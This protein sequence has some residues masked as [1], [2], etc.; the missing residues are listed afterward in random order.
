MKFKDYLTEKHQLTHLEHL[1]DV[2]FLEGMK[3]AK[4]SLD[5]IKKIVEDISKHDT[6]MV[7][8]QKVDG[9]PSIIAGWSPED[10]RF[11]VGTKSFFNKTPKINYTPEDVD[12]NHGHSDGLSKKLKEGLKYLPKVIKKGE[13]LQGDFM[14][15]QDDLKS[16]K[17]DGLPVVTFTPNTITYAVPKDTPLYKK[18]KDA[19]IGVIF[20][21]SYSGNTL[22]S[23]NGSFKISDSQLNPSKDVYYRTTNATIDN[24]GWLPGE[25]KR[26]KSN[27]KNLENDLRSFNQKQ[28]D[29]ISKNKKL[30]L[31]IRTYINEKVRA[32]K[33]KFDKNE[34]KGLIDYIGT[35]YQKDIDKLKSEKGKEKKIKE[36]QEFI[37]EL[38]NY[39]STLYHL[40]DWVYRVQDTKLYILRKLQQLN[41]PETPYIKTSDG[42]KVTDP[43]GFVLSS[44][45]DSGVK[46][47]NRSVFSALNFQASKF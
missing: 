13:I 29:E 33:N 41:S 9:A 12:A 35:R 43:E 47:V 31:I 40:F 11:F 28:I 44:T 42:Y 8:Q 20:H 26:L 30:S 15:S 24:I 16:E 17:I 38:R 25:E 45:S 6:D 23:L 27:I 36:K 32:G 22:D 39:A 19:K 7:I 14:F 10:G 3:G 4:E 37:S 46:M 5:Y 34:I 1:E 2:V 18:I 21:T